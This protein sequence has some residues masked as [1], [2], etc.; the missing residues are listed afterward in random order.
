MSRYERL[1]VSESE[2]DVLRVLWEHGPLTVRQV[3]EV[4]RARGRNW[5]YTT[6]STLLQRLV[7]KRAA[8]CQT[9]GS[10]HVF[11]AAVSREELLR[12]SVQAI[13]DQLCEG[14]A[15]PLVLALVKGHKFTAEEIARFRSLLDEIEPDEGPSSAGGRRKTR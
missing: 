13:A 11:E 12:D 1:G 9:G 2:F 4:L 15:A 14:T 3:G 5:A 8:R 6:V 7:A 10:A